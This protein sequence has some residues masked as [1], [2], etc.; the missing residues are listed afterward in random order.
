M[1]RESYCSPE[2]CVFHRL[3][4]FHSDSLLL[5]WTH[6]YYNTFHF[7]NDV[8]NL[9]LLWTFGQQMVLLI[10]WKF[11][12][13]TIMMMTNQKP[14]PSLKYSEDVASLLFSLSPF[15]Q[16]LVLFY[17]LLK[18]NEEL[19]PGRC[20]SLRERDTWNNKETKSYSVTF[21]FTS[22]C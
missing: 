8:R 21:N 20:I 16:K 5:T 18:N 19:Y 12:L 6:K 10:T 17:C 9:D 11:P 7:L 1:F 13:H 22:L 14:F 3:S 4:S 2:V 15:L